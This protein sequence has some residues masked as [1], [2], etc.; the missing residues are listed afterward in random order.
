M[1][2][3]DAVT[4]CAIADQY[5]VKTIRSGDREYSEGLPPHT[6]PLLTEKYSEDITIDVQLQELPVFQIFVQT[7]AGEEPPMKLHIQSPNSVDEIRKLEEIIN[8][9]LRAS[10]RYVSADLKIDDESKKST[11]ED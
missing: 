7:A 3:S 1:K 8:E 4:D 2:A 10:N 9:E 5:S 6:L 11:A